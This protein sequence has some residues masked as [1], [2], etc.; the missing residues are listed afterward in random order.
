MKMNCE[1]GLVTL[2]FLII[3]IISFSDGVY[4]GYNKNLRD[5]YAKNL[6]EEYLHP[7]EHCGC[8][9]GQPGPPG[10]P[11]VPGL[12]GERGM[13]G[14]QSEKGEMGQKGEIGWKGEIQN[15]HVYYHFIN[16][17]G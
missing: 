9:M 17:Q 12:H 14:R 2:V 4:T 8:F 5:G 1:Q 16:I 15:V 6:R 11:G 13:D 10:V 3:Y 7:K